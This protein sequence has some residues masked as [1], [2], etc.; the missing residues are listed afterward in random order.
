MAM[1]DVAVI[2]ARIRELALNLRLGGARIVST[3]KE[4]ELTDRGEYVLALLQTLWDERVRDR[5]ERNQ[6][7]AGLQRTKTLANFDT[8][9]LE[10]PHGLEL[11]WLTECRFVE[12]KQNLILLG[13]PGTGKTH[14]ATALG[15][16]ACARGYKVLFKRM[17]VLVEELTA[18]FE[19]GQLAKL[20]RRLEMSDLLVIDEWGYLPT[21][22]TGTR[23]LFELIAD[24]YER[25]SLVLT[26][27]M[28][29]PEWNKIFSDERLLMAMID[30]LAH[31]SYLVKHAGE[32]YR[33]THSLMKYPAKP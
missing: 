17:A 14:F 20:K 7:M 25:R 8:A 24:C 4:I 15:L 18:A 6:A 9:C 1:R 32:S 22:V 23:L 27:N 28:P 5:V 11:S 12:A 31:H 2:D 29:I 10:L 3:Y 16:E 13:H 19:A 30:R 33:L 26:T 21:N